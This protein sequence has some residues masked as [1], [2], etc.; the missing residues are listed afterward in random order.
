[1]ILLI[2][3]GVYVN[4]N[5]NGNINMGKN[6]IDSDT[7]KKIDRLN[8]IDQ[9][10][11]ERSKKYLERIRKQGKKQISAIISREAFEELNRRRDASVVAGK[12]LSYGQIIEQAL[13]S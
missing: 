6:M 3:Y 2:H 4:G 11:R 13:L 10:N 7:Q 12:P 5:T 1:M 8:R 9:G